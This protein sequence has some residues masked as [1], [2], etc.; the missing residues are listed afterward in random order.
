M[1][2]CCGDEIKK[3]GQKSINAPCRWC[4]LCLFPRAPAIRPKP[5][6]RLSSRSSL[7]PQQDKIG[8]ELVSITESALEAAI[9]VCG[10]GRHFRSIARAIH[11]IISGKGYVVS[12]A[13]TGHG[14]G[15][16][17]HHPPWVYHDRK[18]IGDPAGRTN[19]FDCA[20]VSEL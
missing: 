18:C 8:T 6:L 12:P 4:P 14:I 11:D 17:F 9:A 16:A 10:P 3:L 7:S 15:R 2:C 20:S 13:F 5:P 19:R 1:H